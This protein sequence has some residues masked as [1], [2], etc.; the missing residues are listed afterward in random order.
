PQRSCHRRSNR[1]QEINIQSWDMMVIIINHHMMMIVNHHI[2]MINHHTRNHDIML[3]HRQ[4]E[5]QRSFHRRS[6]KAQTIH[7]LRGGLDMVVITWNQPTFDQLIH[8][9]PISQKFQIASKL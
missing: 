7:I 9:V 2:I 8:Q 6:N 1:A 3:S 5:P 4:L